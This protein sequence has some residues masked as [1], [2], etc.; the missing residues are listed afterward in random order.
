MYIKN[1]TLW[2][3]RFNFI[4]SVVTCILLTCLYSVSDDVISIAYM[5]IGHMGFSSAK[6]YHDLYAVLCILL[7]KAYNV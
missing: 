5:Y 3:T 4:F 7:I 6:L 1:R 2:N